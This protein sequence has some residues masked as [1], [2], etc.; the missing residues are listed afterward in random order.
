VTVTRS[1]LRDLSGRRVQ[2]EAARRGITLE[3]LAD[4]AGI[5]LSVLRD[6]VTGAGAFDVDELDA[7]AQALEVPV[8]ALLLPVGND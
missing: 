7:I 6:K 1:S 2:Q 3:D 5:P 8:V 4:T